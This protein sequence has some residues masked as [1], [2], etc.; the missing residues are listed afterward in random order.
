MRDASVAPS[1]RRAAKRAAL[2]VVR[3]LT[4]RHPVLLT[5]DAREEATLLDVS[6]PYRV[7]GPTLAVTICETRP[8]R[9]TAVLLGYDG[10]FPTRT[11]WVGSGRDYHG[12]CDLT[13]DVTRGAVTLAGT[14]W[15]EVPLPFPSRRFCWRLTLE[16]S[17]D[18]R[19][20]V[21]GHYVAAARAEIDEAYFHGGTYVDHQAETEGDVPFLVDL[22]RR[23]HAQPMVLEIGCATG[24]LL[25]AMGDAG[26]PAVGLDASPWAVKEARARM[27]AERAWVCDLDAD[28]LPPEVK[29]LTPF[30]TLVMAAVLEHFRDPFATLAR[31][32]SLLSSE[33]LLVITTTNADGL[34]HKLFGRDW[35][36]YFDPTHLGVAAVSA[37]TLRERLPALGWRIVEL[38]T[39]AVWDVN[40]DPTHATLRDWWDADAR[41]RRLLAERDLGDLITCVAVKA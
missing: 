38:T 29:A 33:A 13:L 17:D 15:G 35:E 3:T 28:P 27:R 8:G 14:A 26:V 7:D 4:R 32:T 16:T 39:H 41:F 2:S 6:G 24:G 21:T 5:A 40:G 9:L 20:R 37:R 25:A 11:L 30:R 22:L 19:S 12:P 10:H 34:T 36:G 18:R 31:L 1:L 23:H